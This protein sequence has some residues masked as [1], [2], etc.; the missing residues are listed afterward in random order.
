MSTKTD[1]D[2]AVEPPAL[3]NGIYQHYKGNRYEVIGLAKH[4]ETQELLVV[5]RPLSDRPMPELWVRPYG[6]FMET[7]M[8]DGKEIPRFRRMAG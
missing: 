7:V 3:Q 5:Y 4:T 2:G 8:V 6:M 1:T